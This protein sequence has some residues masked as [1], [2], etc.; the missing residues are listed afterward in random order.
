MNAAA[1]NVT[2]VAVVILKHRVFAAGSDDPAR[3]D[4]PRTEARTRQQHAATDPADAS[5]ADG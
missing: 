5:G 2:I 3:T 1:I 4:D